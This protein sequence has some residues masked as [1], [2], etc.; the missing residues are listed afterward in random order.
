MQEMDAT[1]VILHAIL[2]GQQVTNAKL[3]AM[4]LRLVR[5][6]GHVADIHERLALVE[7]H[8]ADIHERLASAEGD[9]AMGE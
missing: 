6:E 8:V 2:E 4:D 7:G 1:K 9:V 5:V 3:E